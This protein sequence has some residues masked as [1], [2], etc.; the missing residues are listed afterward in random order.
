MSNIERNKA[1]AQKFLTGLAAADAEAL[2]PLLT[3][4]AKIWVSGNLPHS[5]LK[6]AS[7][8]LD[9]LPS[10]PRAFDGP[11]TIDA[12]TFTAEDD[13]VAVEAE[14]QAVTVMGNKYHN[15]YHYLF[16][17]RD[18]KISL[19]KEYMD[20]GHAAETFPPP[21]TFKELCRTGKPV[22]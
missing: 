1:I 22:A 21:Y 12:L 9:G 17:I 10:M 15:K 2:R 20:T 16:I 3:D 5:G 18:D 19:V 6:R 14:G 7:D 11:L 8:I 4:D 13:R